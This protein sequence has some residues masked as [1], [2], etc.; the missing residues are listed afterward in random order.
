MGWT[1]TGFPW[2][3]NDTAIGNGAGDVTSP[4]ALQQLALGGPVDPSSSTD[5]DCAQFSDGVPGGGLGIELLM[6]SRAAA[7]APCQGTVS[8]CGT[9]C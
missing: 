2:A 7:G 3:D 5:L 4:R 1:E 6:D 9:H 8:M